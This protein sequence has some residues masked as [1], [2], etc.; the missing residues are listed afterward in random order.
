M[1]LNIMIILVYDNHYIAHGVFSP[2]RI[3]QKHYSKTNKHHCDLQI[4][5]DKEQND[6]QE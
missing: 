3:M 1:T 5:K 6:E 2:Q 4:D